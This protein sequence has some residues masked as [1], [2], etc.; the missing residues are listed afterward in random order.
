MRLRALRLPFEAQQLLNEIKAN[1]DLSYALLQC[2]NSHFTHS[3]SGTS[4]SIKLSYTVV[5]R[6]EHE[7]YLTRLRHNSWLGCP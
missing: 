5:C 6:P 2:H 1:I 4:A 7:F 3:S